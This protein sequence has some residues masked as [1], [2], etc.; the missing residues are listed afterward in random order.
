MNLFASAA[1]AAAII[2]LVASPARSQLSNPATPSVGSPVL[3]RQVGP[4]APPSR[5]IAPPVR[6]GPVPARLTL[7]QALDEA[8]ARSPAVAAARAEVAAAEARVRQSGYRSNPELSIEVENFGGTGELRG[9]RS[10]E[11]TVAI[12]HRLDLGGKRRARIAAARANLAIGRLGLAVA[13][14]DLAHSVRQQFAGAVAARERLEQAD[15]RVEWAKELARIAGILVDAGREPPLRGLRARSALAQA[16]AEQE[17]A[18]AD[19]LAA[20]TTLAALFG[21]SAPVQ[22]VAGSSLDL[23]PAAV[24]VERSLEVLVADA[25]RTAAAAELDVQL[26]ERRL[27]PAIGAGVRHLRDTGDFGLVAGVSLPLRV[28]DRNQG[29][30]A[31]ARQALAAAEARRSLALAGITARGRNAIAAVEAAERR[32]TALERNALPE[33][34]E[35]LRLAE[36]A[37]GEGKVPLIELLDARNAYTDTQAALT[38]ARLA[39][40]LATAELGRIAARQE[41]P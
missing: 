36:F 19:E 15:E 33:G 27:D 2:T 37:Y 40:A 30:I 25:E 10:A 7:V 6:T 20:R 9:A 34:R 26:A 11:A 23:S 38:E 24:D 32:V 5:A 8:A 22:A 35:A 39:L 16:L 13:Q 17:A 14:A 4:P 12:N 28:F 31:A 18:R 21:V 41:N 3:E 1:T 29:N